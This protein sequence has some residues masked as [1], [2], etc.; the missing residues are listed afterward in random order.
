[1]LAAPSGT[2]GNG[3]AVQ[4][5]S[6]ALDYRTVMIQEMLR[7][8]E[9]Q[10]REYKF[11]DAVRTCEEAM[12]L[13]AEPQQ[14]RMVAEA[15]ALARN[16]ESMADYCS[17]P[18]VVARKLLSLSDFYL[19]YPLESASWRPLPEGLAAA[20]GMTDD[21]L[22][23]AVPEDS[24]AH[25]L[26][27][28]YIPKSAIDGGQIVFAAKGDIYITENEGEAW[29]A[30]Q[31]LAESLSG[32]GNEVFPMLADG[33]KT[34][35]FSSDGLYGMGGYDIYVCRWDERRKCWGEPVN[36]GFPYSSPYDDFLF[37]N[38]PDGRYSIFASNRDCTSGSVYVYVVEYEATPVRK[39]IYDPARLKGLLDMPA[40]KSSASLSPGM[41][42]YVSKLQE[43]KTLQDS[44]SAFGQAIETSRAKLAGASG[45]SHRI[46]VKDILRREQELPRMEEQLAQRS[47]ELQEIEIDLVMN[48]ETPDPALLPSQS[49]TAAFDFS[50][51]TPGEPLEMVVR[52]P[53]PAFD[54]T[55][56]VL[57]QGRLFKE[58]ALPQGVVYQ[59]Q[60]C[61]MTTTLDEAGLRGLSPVF[62]TVSAGK[63]TYSAGLFHTYDEALAALPAVRKAGFKKSFI[64]AFVGGKRVSLSEAR[65]AEASLARSFVLRIHPDSG[66]SLD[67]STLEA[68]RSASA[69]DLQRSS[70]GGAVFYLLG[71]VPS[72]AEAS[73]LA[74]RLRSS[75]GLTIDIIPA[76]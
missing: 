1:M 58:V 49:A 9:I 50:R 70:S 7:K 5:D 32:S 16:G 24:A 65:A 72:A 76:D 18:K 8:A 38:T 67:S 45:V 73:A 51:R 52:N 44:I 25:S 53:E 34:L 36:M 43:I 42:E 55:F 63:Y 33:G 21:P 37:L 17:T 40:E 20:L 71:P 48:G 29:S 23:G 10:R 39:G 61:V 26:P 74:D 15:L 69:A 28:T 60:M 64:A 27:P 46:L 6:V 57:P 31:L 13:A 2:A 66:N 41:R 11:S 35:Y 12:S 68:I 54:F 19:Y 22:D 75:T 14:Q 59:V 4:Q 3:F 30:P 47:Q 56:A 62:E